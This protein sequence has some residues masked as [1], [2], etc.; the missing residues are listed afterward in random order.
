[1]SQSHRER[2]RE[3]TL[4]EI[5][6][7]A[8]QQMRDEG[9]AAVSLRGI[10]NTMGMTAPAIYR[11]YA[12]RDDLITALIV[13]AYTALGDAVISAFD[14]CPADDYAGRFY[15]GAQAYRAWGLAHPVDFGL[16]FGTP[17][18]GYH[19]PPERTVP[20][21]QRAFS[22]FITTLQQ[23]CEKGLARIP[24]EYDHAPQELHQRLS[25]WAASGSYNGLTIPV[26]HFSLTEWGLMH[27]LIALEI[28]GQLNPMA[29]QATN[30]LFNFEMKIMLNRLGLDTSSLT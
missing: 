18:P 1:M 23:A 20:L 25:E 10:A 9:T 15:A 29:G 16:I 5:K 11:Y 14:A 27:G 19:A 7:V 13:D 6:K 28:N 4:E 8:K 26:F 12:R 17:V 24:P 2:V 30:D 21:V 22:P 3:A